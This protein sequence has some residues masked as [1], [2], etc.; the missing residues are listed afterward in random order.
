MLQIKNITKTFPNRVLLNGFSYSFPDH[1]L[2]LLT[3]ANG[4]GKSTLIYILAGLD[5]RYQ[6]ECLFDG[7][8]VKK[9]NAEKRCRYRQKDV[10]LLFSHGNLYSF[11]DVEENRTFGVKENPLDFALL[12]K[13][14]SVSSLSG[15]EELLV[16]LSNELAKEKKMYLM[17][18]V[19]SALDENHLKQVMDILMK[20]SEKSLII[21]ATHDQRIMSYG[22]RIS[23]TNE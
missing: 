10:G 8:N 19:T 6:G 17:D 18:E 13:K 14:R 20:Q 4:C 9:A 2:Y 16:A 22:T 1:G 12:E 23:M 21:M 15:G 7:F 3:G 5:T 11:L